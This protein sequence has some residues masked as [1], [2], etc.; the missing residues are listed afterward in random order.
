MPGIVLGARSR[1]MK[2]MVPDLKKMWARQWERH[3]S[4]EAVTTQHSKS[5]A[6]PY[7]GHY[8]SRERNLSQ[9]W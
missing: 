4:K 2:D 7:P 6:K 1:K 9:N 5:M 8:V 3:L